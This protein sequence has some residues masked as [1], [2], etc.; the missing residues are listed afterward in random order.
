MIF[1]KNIAMMNFHIG[2]I[3]FSIVKKIIFIFF[4][5]GVVFVMGG[6]ITDGSD[7]TPLKVEIINPLDG[8]TITEPSNILAE[9]NKEPIENIRFYI[10]S[11]QV[12]SLTIPPFEVSWDP[13]DK[14]TAPSNA[15]FTIWV[16]AQNN[17]DEEAADTVNVSVEVPSPPISFQNT[18]ETN[19]GVQIQFLIEDAVYIDRIYV[20][21]SSTGTDEKIIVNEELQKFDELTLPS[22][23][24]YF[25]KSCGFRCPYYVDIYGETRNGFTVEFEKSFEINHR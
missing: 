2:T 11:S 20:T 22:E 12:A 13:S 5:L 24:E 16:L 15:T 21:E 9:T 3:I 17:S 25:E 10:N 7:E 8:A 14:L 18:I 19:E 4:A 1:G 6:C 23:A